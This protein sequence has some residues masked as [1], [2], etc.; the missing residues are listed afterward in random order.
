MSLHSLFSE[1]FAE[2]FIFSYQ[3]E[4]ILVTNKKVEFNTSV[5]VFAETEFAMPLSD[6]GEFV[7]ELSIEH[8]Q[9]W[10]RKNRINDKTMQTIEK[11]I[12]IN[13]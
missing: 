1:E 6:M 11:T 10:L 13:K 5:L 8:F 4:T 2:V 3:E 7:P 9:R 12:Q